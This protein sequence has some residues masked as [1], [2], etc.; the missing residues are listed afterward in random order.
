[1]TD[2]R[3]TQKKTA[4][5]YASWVMSVVLVILQP[6]TIY[7]LR[8]SAEKLER[9]YESSIIT[10]A[11]LEYATKDFD[12]RIGKLEASVSRN[13]ENIESMRERVSNLEGRK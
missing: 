11:R 10:T 6:I 13:R 7:Y 9:V 5:N 4:L 2:F 12:S 8:S 1:M 3:D